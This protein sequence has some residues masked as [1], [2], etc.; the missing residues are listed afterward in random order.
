M[1][2]HGATDVLL[3]R[4]GSRKDRVCKEATPTPDRFHRYKLADVA[5]ALEF[6]EK[7]DLIAVGRDVWKQIQG[8][9]QGNAFSPILT[10]LLLDVSQLRLW[11]TPLSLETPLVRRLA[12]IHSTPRKWVATK[13][14]VDDSV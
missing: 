7:D 13:F 1:L 12:A 3:C 2:R 6:C 11:K 8:L 10:R 14:H 5:A 4:E 9:G